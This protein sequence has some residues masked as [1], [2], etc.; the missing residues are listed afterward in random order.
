[1]IFRSSLTSDQMFAI[2]VVV[3]SLEHQI[4]S[5]RVFWKAI[6]LAGPH[7]LSGHYECKDANV[8]YQML[9]CSAVIWMV[10]LPT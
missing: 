6:H 3:A 7:L 2:W 1:M 9:N 4:R 5:I 10:E 8:L